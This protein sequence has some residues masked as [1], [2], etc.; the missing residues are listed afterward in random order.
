LGCSAKQ[1]EELGKLYK[2]NAIVF[3]DESAIPELVLLQ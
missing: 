3:C 2:Q 1:G